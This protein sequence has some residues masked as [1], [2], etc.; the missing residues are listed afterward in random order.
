MFAPSHKAKSLPL[1]EDEAAE[2][3]VAAA[4]HQPEFPRALAVKLG[5]N[6]RGS[7]R[8]RKVSEVFFF[9]AIELAG[10]FQLF[11]A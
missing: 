6:L 5:G 3:E 4:L 2:P 11:E 10:V 7:I 9:F 1:K 8:Q